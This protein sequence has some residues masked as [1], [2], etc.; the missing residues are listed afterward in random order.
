MIEFKRADQFDRGL[1]YKLLCESYAS[2]LEAKSD[3]KHGFEANLQKTED[4][5]F[6]G[7]NSSG[8]AVISTFDY[9]PIGF[10]SWYAEGA[11]VG[12][13]GHNC[14]VPLHRRK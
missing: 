1:I 3:Y 8:K 2:L 4:E 11:E 12:S 6:D 10:V 9:K 5:L 14:I 13:I 7:P